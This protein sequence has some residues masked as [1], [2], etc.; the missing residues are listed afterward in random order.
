MVH[1]KDVK[2]SLLCAYPNFISGI[3]ELALMGSAL[4]LGVREGV[5]MLESLGS[6][7]RDPAVTSHCLSCQG[8]EPR[9]LEL[10][11]TFSLIP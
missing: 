10:G 4:G 8:L 11:P 6:P 1:F 7:C 3:R 2:C 5:N 9:P